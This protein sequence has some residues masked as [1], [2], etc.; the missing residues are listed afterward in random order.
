[1]TMS[2]V[3]TNMALPYHLMEATCRVFPRLSDLADIGQAAEFAGVVHA[4][5][6]DEIIAG[7]KS[8]IIGFGHGVR[9]LLVQGYGP[10][11]RAR[12]RRFDQ[13]HGFLDGAPQIQ[14]A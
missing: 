14:H 13:R 11:D 6:D 9:P 1:M 12:T 3:P 2:A 10:L 4:I 7:F 8:D 5:T